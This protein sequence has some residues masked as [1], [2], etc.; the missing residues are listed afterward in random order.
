MPALETF[1]HRLRIHGVPGAAGA[2][3]VPVDRAAEV[4]AELAPIFDLLEEQG[5]VPRNS[6]PRASR[7]RPVPVPVPPTRLGGSL[8]R[9]ERRSW[10]SGLRRRPPPL[11]G[12]RTPGALFSP[13]GERRP[14]VWTELFPSECPWCAPSSSGAS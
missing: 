7:A 5:G 10:R 3:G 6:W 2:A 13:R 4:T 14:N 11:H 8:V 12:Q 1:L 9:H